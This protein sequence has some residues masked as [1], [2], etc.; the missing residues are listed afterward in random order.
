MEKRREIE[1]VAYELFERNGRI[2][3]R[4]VE[5]WLEAERIV[6]MR[7]EPAEKA[8]KTAPKKSVASSAVKSSKTGA[9]AVRKAVSVK[10]VPAGKP[11]KK[12]GSKEA[13]I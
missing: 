8:A 4:E 6:C 3:G 5:H 12:A 13:S 10:K 9:S 7:C 2:H 1:R 11:K